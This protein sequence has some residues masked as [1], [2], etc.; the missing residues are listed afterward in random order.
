LNGP[1]ASASAT[2]PL[3][4]TLLASTPDTTY[5][6]DTWHWSD[7]SYYKITAVD[8]NGNESPPD[9][10]GPDQI[11]GIVSDDTPPVTYLDQNYPNPFNPHTTIRF[12]LP[13]HASV[14]LRIYSV[15]G[16][17]VRS[18]V[19]RT[20]HPGRYAETWDGRDERGRPVASGVYFYRLRAGD[21]RQTRKMTLLR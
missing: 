19:D 2:S 17:L 11:V 8:D 18:L 20:L 6:D 15:S 3:D 4:E 5:T 7:N 10:I 1:P 13:S 21:F 14:E 16:Q 12:G 9:S